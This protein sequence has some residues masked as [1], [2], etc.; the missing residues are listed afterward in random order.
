MLYVRQQS[1]I[2]YAEAK[3]EDNTKKFSQNLEI[4]IDAMQRRVFELK[5]QAMD[6]SF[7]STDAMAIVALEKI[8]QLMEEAIAL[9]AKAHSYASYKERFGN[10]RP[11]RNQMTKYE[12]F[13]LLN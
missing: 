12:L 11:A 10:S 13:K 1:L 2:L 4:L 7:L 5:N 8:A 9:S 6:P 3:K